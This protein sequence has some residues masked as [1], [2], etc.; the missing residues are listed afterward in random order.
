MTQKTIDYRLKTPISRDGAS[1]AALT[2]REP[3]LGDMID[4]EEAGG[5][6]TAQIG[7]LLA[8]MAGV[9]METFRLVSS[10]DVRAMKTLADK[11]WG[12]EM[13]NAPVAGET[14]PS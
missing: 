3:T 5:G 7:M 10:R 11:T 1:I 2:L 4:V 13:G 9:P 6:D 14:S 8:R 12:D